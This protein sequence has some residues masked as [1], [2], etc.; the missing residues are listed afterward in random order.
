VALGVTLSDRDAVDDVDADEPK[1]RDDVGDPVEL[2]D[3]VAAAV[4][5]GE[6]VKVELGD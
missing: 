1:L 3:V 5:D 6:L 2:L 4:T